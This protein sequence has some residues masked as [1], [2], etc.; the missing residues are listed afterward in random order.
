M[1]TVRKL[2]YRSVMRQVLLVTLAF[3]SLF[4]FIDFVD[5]AKRIGRDGYTALDAAWTKLRLAV[6]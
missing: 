1:K 4:F 2:V 5:Q 3:S 6:V